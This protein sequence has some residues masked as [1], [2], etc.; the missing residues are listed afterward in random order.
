[1]SD[2]NASPGEDPDLHKLLAAEIRRRRTSKGLTQSQLAAKTAYSREYTGRAERPGAGF[3]SP[4]VVNAIDVVLEAGGEL[5]VLHAR[6][7]AQRHARRLLH[8]TGGNAGV[9]VDSPGGGQIAATGSRVGDHPDEARNDALSTDEAA[10]SLSRMQWFIQVNVDDDVLDA[11]AFAINDVVERYETDG[12]AVLA[13]RVRDLRSLSHRYLQGHQHPRQRERLYLIA[14]KL[15]GLLGYM[16]VNQGRPS[17]GRTYCAEAFQLASQIGAKDVQAWIRGTESLAAYYSGAYAEALELAKDGQRYA[18]GGPQAVRL[19]LNG[20]AR[21]HGKLHDLSG[22]HDAV[23]RGFELWSRAEQADRFG[24][25]PCIS[26]EPCD[27]PRAAANAATAYLSAGR[28]EETLEH[29]R[30]AEMNVELSD[31]DWSKALVR[32]DVATAMVIGGK[33]EVEEAA[34]LGIEALR[35]TDGN[36]IDSV[37]KRACELHEKLQKWADLNEVQEFRSALLRWSRTNVMSM[38]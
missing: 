34:S 10:E 24:I 14:A 36:P 32:L 27:M 9:A 21:A 33:P 23:S 38:E 13:R 30:A 31:S 8:K 3:P 25:I 2:A 6:A 18:G 5:V 17:L 37:K 22:V 1:V 26:F 11:L 20:E 16:A 29:A 12:P 19:A 15:A 28:R 7:D 35:R 4:E